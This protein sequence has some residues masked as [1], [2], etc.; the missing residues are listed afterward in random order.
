MGS[1]CRKLFDDCMGNI[2]SE[3]LSLLKVICDNNGGCLVIPSHVGGFT[4]CDIYYKP[5]KLYYVNGEVSVDFEVNLAT[6]VTYLGEEM[7][8]CLLIALLDFLTDN[9]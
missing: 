7:G 5:T 3:M 8:V 9:V 4:H 1:S 6:D 2:E